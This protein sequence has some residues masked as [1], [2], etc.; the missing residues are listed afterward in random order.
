MSSGMLRS[1]G[2]SVGGGAALAAVLGA[3]SCAPLGT[4]EPATGDDPNINQ[5]TSVRQKDL[6]YCAGGHR[7]KA[8]VLG[9]NCRVTEK[10]CQVCQCQ[11][12]E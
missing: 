3:L 11:T 6:P 8:C 1:V 12:L 5:M 4:S 9:E 7:N 2:A 10:G